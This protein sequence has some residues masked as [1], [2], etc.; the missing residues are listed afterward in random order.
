MAITN[1]I[2]GSALTVGATP[3]KLFTTNTANRTAYRVYNP[4]AS[5]V[6][7]MVL[8]LPANSPSPNQATVLADA[9]F[10]IAPGTTI[11]DQISNAFDLWI[12]SESA[13]TA[14]VRG[15]EIIGA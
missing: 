12:V 11:E 13:T 9:D 3:Q 6:S 4:K 5:T 15:K 10:C 7:V 1:I 8:A 14:V 2:Q